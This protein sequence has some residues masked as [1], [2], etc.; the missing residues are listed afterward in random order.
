MIY[1][2]IF[3]HGPYFSFCFYTE[4]RV[5]VVVQLL[6]LVHLFA[7][8]GLQHTTL[9]C[10]PLLLEFAHTH[11]CW[12]CDAIQPPYPLSPPSPLPSIFPSIRVFSS[13]LALRIRWPK[14]DLQQVLPVNIKGGFLLGLIGLISFQSKG[15]SRVFSNTTV[16]ID[17]DSYY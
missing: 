8:H 13:E 4:P 3:S 9:S 15:C 14:L 1:H 6:S 7:T 5:V 11:V 16:Q 17:Y 2:K 12:V 10:P